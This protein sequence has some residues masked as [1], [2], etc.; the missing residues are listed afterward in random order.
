MTQ[1]QLRDLYRLLH[2]CDNWEIDED[3]DDW[4]NLYPHEK[5]EAPEGTVEH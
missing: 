4:N 3:G 2:F 1:D 5:V